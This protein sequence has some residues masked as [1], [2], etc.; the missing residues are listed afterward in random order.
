MAEAG[1]D[2]SPLE[3]Q[4]LVPAGTE[5]GALK[6]L[7][8][9]GVER[10]EHVGRGELRLTEPGPLR[11]VLAAERPTAIYAVRRLAATELVGLDPETT[12]RAA[13]ELAGVVAG[14]NR[15]RLDGYRLTVAHELGRPPAAVHRLSQHV[16]ARL[17]LERSVGR[18]DLVLV[19]RPGAD[20]LELAARL[21]RKGEDAA[22]GG[23]PPRRTSPLPRTP[24]AP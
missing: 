1:A 21:P 8:A 20:G 12:L 18:P 11:T 2:S 22:T 4:L 16:G 10:V 14:L 13:L 6:E 3:L 5:A 15:G 17:G 19:L 23:A 7:R 24:Q 9:L